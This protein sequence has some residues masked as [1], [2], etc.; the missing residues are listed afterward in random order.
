MTSLLDKSA[1]RVW[2]DEHAALLLGSI[3]T[4][5][6]PIDKYEL[7]DFARDH[8]EKFMQC[9]DLLPPRDAEIM[10]CFALLQK[11]PTDLSILFGKAGHR[12]EEDL[13]KAAHKMAGLIEF[14][15]APPIERIAPILERNG[16][17]VWAGR[18]S[19]AAAMWEYQRCRDFAEMSRL[20]GHRGLRQ[21]M[22]RTFKTLHA[23]SG[24]E[25]GLLAGWILWLVDGSNPA[26]KGYIGRKR[27]GRLHKLGPLV[28]RTFEVSAK[29]LNP[30]ATGRGGKGQR[31]DTVKITRKMKFLLRG[32]NG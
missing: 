29:Q 14:G 19:L 24:R 1:L 26:G 9:V 17:L 23:T 21:Q 32:M 4:H 8:F 5:S 30:R 18:N 31:P 3:E 16:L 13:H 15:P 22:L 20:T 2:T 28:F 7:Q 27:S 12:A 11:R 6:S 10:L 25:E